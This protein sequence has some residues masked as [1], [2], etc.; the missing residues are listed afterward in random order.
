MGF[1]LAVQIT[2]N[3]NEIFPNNTFVAFPGGPGYFWKFQETVHYT[4]K[5]LRNN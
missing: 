1:D 4:E 3:L 2:D 5:H